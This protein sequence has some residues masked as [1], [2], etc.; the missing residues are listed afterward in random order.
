MSVFYRTPVFSHEYN[1]LYGNPPDCLF[2]CQFWTCW[3][4]GKTVKRIVYIPFTVG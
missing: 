4:S 1:A 3:C 2:V